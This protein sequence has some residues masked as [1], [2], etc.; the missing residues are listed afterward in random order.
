MILTIDQFKQI[1]AAGGGLV[2]DASTLTLNQ[3]RDIVTSAQN[4]DQEPLWP[5]RPPTTRAIRSSPRF[6][7]LR[8]DELTSGDQTP[9]VTVPNERAPC[10]L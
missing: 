4:N 5:Y 8:P 1:A 3:I 7:R 6:D 2:I 10:C 9:A